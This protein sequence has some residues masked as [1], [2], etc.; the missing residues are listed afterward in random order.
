MFIK[1]LFTNNY[2]SRFHTGGQANIGD[3][4]G[5]IWTLTLQIHFAVKMDNPLDHVRLTSEVKPAHK[6]NEGR[7]SATRDRTKI[8]LVVK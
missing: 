1:N 2:L 5:K 8:D 4:S 7:E 6:R 3:D